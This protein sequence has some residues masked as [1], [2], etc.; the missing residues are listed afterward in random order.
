MV[1]S[2]SRNLSENLFTLHYLLQLLEEIKLLVL[3][4]IQIEPRWSDFHRT[5]S[6]YLEIYVLFI[7]DCSDFVLLLE[8]T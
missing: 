2:L 6:R 7:L 5:L 4:F 8:E 1:F 3:L